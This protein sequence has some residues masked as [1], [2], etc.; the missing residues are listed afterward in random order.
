LVGGIGIM[1]T[2]YT[3]VL[4]QTKNIGIMKAVGAQ[5]HDIMMIF[6]FE[7][8]IL[9]IVGGAIGTAI[10]LM[11][12]L[13]VQYAAANA[14]FEVLKASMAPDLIFGAILFSFVV[15]AVSG[16]TPAIRAAKMS[17]AKALRYE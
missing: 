10:G 2:M 3:S 15:G 5:E 6:L 8:G 13:L 4:E 12:G 7:A 17:P 1:N 11:I 16:L 14:G 9:G